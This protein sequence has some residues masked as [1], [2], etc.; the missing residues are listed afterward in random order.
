MR[1]YEIKAEGDGL[2]RLVEVERPDPEA[3]PGQVVVRMRAASLNY[4]DQPMVKGG[5][6]TPAPGAFI[7]LS[8]GAGEVI[9]VGP[10]VSRFK[11]GDRVCPTFFQVWVDGKPPAGFGALGGP[12][13]GVLAQKVL[14]HE[15]GLV[16]IP[17]DMSYEEAA[18]LPCAALTAWNALFVA[19]KPLKSGQT[20]LVLGTG[21]VSIFALQF[22]RAAGARVIATSSSDAKIERLKAMGADACINYR[23][24]PEWQD[25]VQRLTGGVE[26]PGRDGKMTVAGGGVDVVVEV[27]GAGTLP[28]SYAALGWGGKVSLIGVMTQPGD[29][30]VALNPISLAFKHGSVH[31]IMVGSRVMF[32][33]MLRAMTTNGIRPVVDKVFAWTEARQAYETAIAGDFF[34]KVVI[35]I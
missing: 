7:P 20:V 15:D 2:D 8:D 1:V 6:H 23:T 11:I 33:D 12:R 21:G 32:E 25:E 5:Y 3:G 18:C 28:R 34:G 22:A 27:G 35:R 10:G 4:R 14:V 16:G 26:G 30:P 9:A 24:T 31:G 19:G 29:N 13:D 17:D